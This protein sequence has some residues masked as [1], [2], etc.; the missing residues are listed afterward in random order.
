MVVGFDLRSYRHGYNRDDSRSHAMIYCLRDRT[1]AHQKVVRE[2]AHGSRE[3]SHG[4]EHL[5]GCDPTRSLAACAR[6]AV[7]E[8]FTVGE[9]IAPSAVGE[10]IAAFTVG[11]A[12]RDRV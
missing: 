11:E 4:R 5:L 2:R 12:R 10:A 6:C 8:A 9:A 1:S 3:N 7:G